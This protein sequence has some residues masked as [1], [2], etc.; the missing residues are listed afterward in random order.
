MK[1]QRSGLDLDG[2]RH[3]PSE[4]MCI[5]GDHVRGIIRQTGRQ[6]IAQ[7]KVPEVPEPPILTAGE[8]LVVCCG[9]A[10]HHWRI[11]PR[12]SEICASNANMSNI[13]Q[14]KLSGM[15]QGSEHCRPSQASAKIGKIHLRDSGV[16]VG[17]GGRFAPTRTPPPP[18]T[19]MHRHTSQTCARC[20]NGRSPEGF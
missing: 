8:G 13:G 1:Q 14:A 20:R 16:C 12:G 3:F 2:A 19:H 11:E 18:H 10:A 9:R 17:G 6:A 15:A 5:E 7:H 4:L